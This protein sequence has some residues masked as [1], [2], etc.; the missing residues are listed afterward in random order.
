MV[1]DL[2]I[3]LVITGGIYMAGILLGEGGMYQVS[4]LQAAFPQFGQQW[5]FGLTYYFRLRGTGLLAADKVAQFR[6]LYNW[7]LKYGLIIT[8][9]AVA[10]LVPFRASISVHLAARGCVYASTASCLPV[11]QT[12]FGRQGY[13]GLQGDSFTA[14]L[15]ALAASC[16]FMMFKAGLY[17]FMDWGF[18]AIS[19]LVVFLLVGIPGLCIAGVL[20]TPAAIIAAMYA[21]QLVL[22]FV[23][24][25]RIHRLMQALGLPAAATAD[26]PAS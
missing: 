2:S 26:P 19:S 7:M 14:F 25:V 12:I 4:S 10:S 24:A 20:G 15:P 22:G 17:A 21:P 5:F 6:A 11:Y 18:M 23:F 1:V 8:V 3:Q 9:A 16:L 13:D